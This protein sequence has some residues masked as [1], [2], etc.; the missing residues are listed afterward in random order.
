M[1]KKTR[2]L[3]IVSVS[4]LCLV[5]GCDAELPVEFGKTP[6]STPTPLDEIDRLPAEMSLDWITPGETTQEEIR[7]RLGDP[8]KD[9]ICQEGQITWEG[10][11]SLYDVSKDCSQGYTIYQ[12]EQQISEEIPYRYNLEHQIHFQEGIV[13][14]FIEGINTLGDQPEN[15]LVKELGQPE[16]VTWS[17]FGGSTRA[18]L[19]CE[20]GLMLHGNTIIGVKWLFHFEPIPYDQCLTDFEFWIPRI[21]PNVD[22]DMDVM[23]DPWGFTIPDDMPEGFIDIWPKPNSELL[24]EAYEKYIERERSERGIGVYVNP[25]QV[26]G[27][28]TDI[29]ADIILGNT[30]LKINGKEISNEY[31]LIDDSSVTTNNIGLYWTPAL[32]S[33][34][35][36]VDLEFIKMDGSLI[37]YSWQFQLTDE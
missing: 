16:D 24:L 8:V 2:V 9:Y 13:W 37:T 32:E 10:L 14:L 22:T 27:V 12:Y 31:L 4:V 21:D 11:A 35:Y 28:G 6:L 29:N 33:G 34:S 7:R 25:Q 36:T 20:Q 1:M 30:I 26:Y 18:I 23:K 19:Y 5:I 15:N 17:W 3:W